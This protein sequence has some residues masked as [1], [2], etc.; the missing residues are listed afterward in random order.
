MTHLRI[1]GCERFVRDVKVD[2]DLLV[3]VELAEHVGVVGLPLANRGVQANGDQRLR[4]VT[5]RQ[6]EEPHDVLKLD[7]EV[8]GLQGQEIKRIRAR[9][10]AR[11]RARDRARAKAEQ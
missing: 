8:L 4:G 10:G 2:G 3:I 11:G 9:G 5:L 6:Q 7:P 1:L